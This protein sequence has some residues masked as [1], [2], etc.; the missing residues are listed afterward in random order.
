MDQ[1]LE[2]WPLRAFADEPQ[3]EV[4]PPVA[5]Q[6]RG[7]EKCLVSLLLDE[8]ADRD[9]PRRLAGG[10]RGALTVLEVDTVIDEVHGRLSVGEPATSSSD[11]TRERTLGGETTRV[12]S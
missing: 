6:P 4:E 8:P 1:P 9:D 12:R 5:E 3:A 11:A 2:P 10:P 7:E